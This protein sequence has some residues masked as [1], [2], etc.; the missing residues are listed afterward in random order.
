MPY[1]RMYATMHDFLWSLVRAPD[2]SHSNGS[3]QTPP[4]SQAMICGQRARSSHAS[5]L[6]ELRRKL[7]RTQAL[8][9][10]AAQSQDPNLS[11]GA[12]G[13]SM[14]AVQPNRPLAQVDEDASSPISAA[15]SQ[16]LSTSSSVMRRYI[17]TAKTG[18]TVE[19]TSRSGSR[20]PTTLSEPTAAPVPATF[21]FLDLPPELRVMV[22][23]YLLIEPAYDSMHGRSTTRYLHT[24]K[25]FS[26]GPPI[27]RV[28][29]EVRNEFIPLC[30]TNYDL[31][32]CGGPAFGTEDFLTVLERASKLRLLQ[33]VRCLQLSTMINWR[34]WCCP[35]RSRADS[36]H[37]LA[38]DVRLEADIAAGTFKAR[39]RRSGTYP[40]CPSGQSVVDEWV[41]M[42][43]RLAVKPMREVT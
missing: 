3:A 19:Q 13:K 18:N 36:G 41:R 37:P 17:G 21:R 10:V 2:V 31:R 33:H 32:L 15:P 6:S 43:S 9:A 38:I 42:I 16:V 25:G 27:S 23:H 30:F 29:R 24:W 5:A 40:C 7:G 35:T 11:T 12:I 14:A 8:Q 1:R 4:I 39:I 20:K 34:V 22:Y 28:C 26:G